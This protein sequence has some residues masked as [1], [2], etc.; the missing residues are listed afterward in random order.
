M[1]LIPK[2]EIVI[3]SAPS[4]KILNS[5]KII[6][7][8]GGMKCAGCVSAVEK[9]LIQ[10]PGVKSVCVNLATE[11][12]VIEAEAGTVDAEALAQGLTAT[13]FPSQLRTA[14]RAGDKSAITNSEVRQRQE[15]QGTIRQLVIASLLL[16]L[17]GIGHFGNIGSTIFPFLNDIWFHCGLATIAIIIPGRPILVEGWLGWRRG[18]PNMNTLIGLGTLTAYTASLGSFYQSHNLG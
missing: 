14:K 12:A 10:H 5:E 6:L 16:V 17:S 2:T 18:A 4:T 9:Q 1:Q 3:E 7:D 15:M 13:G 11:V 8:V